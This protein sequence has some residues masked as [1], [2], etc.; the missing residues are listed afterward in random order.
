MSPRGGG[1]GGGWGFK[2]GKGR[3]QRKR[4]KLLSTCDLQEGNEE[5]AAGR[6]EFGDGR[7]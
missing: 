3:R 5:A 4:D 6:G 2:Q 7:G 1:K